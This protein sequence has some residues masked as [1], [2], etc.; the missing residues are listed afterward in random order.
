MPSTWCVSPC[1]LCLTKGLRLLLLTPHV[2][3]S[4][5]IIIIIILLVLLLII[6]MVMQ[7]VVED[8]Q[9]SYWRKPSHGEMLTLHY[10]MF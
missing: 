4:I 5:L 7:T 1:V 9:G 3:K 10:I 6:T 8:S 2:D